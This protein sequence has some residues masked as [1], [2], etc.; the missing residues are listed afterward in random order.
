MAYELVMYDVHVCNVAV[1]RP[2]ICVCFLVLEVE[3]EGKIFL[4]L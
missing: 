4:K 2:E 3:A 1:A